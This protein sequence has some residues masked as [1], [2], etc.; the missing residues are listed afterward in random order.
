MPLIHSEE[1]A[2]HKQI[3]EGFVGELLD[4]CMQGTEEGGPTA[5]AKAFQIQTEQH[6]AVIDMFGRYP[7]R[8]GVLGREDTSEEKVWLENPGVSWAR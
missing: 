2:L 4:D 6:K 3:S 8:N 7:Y 1:P 5:L